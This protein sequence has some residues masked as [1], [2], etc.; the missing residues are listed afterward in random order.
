MATENK[1]SIYL[2]STL[3][4]GQVTRDPALLPQEHGDDSHCLKC[5]GYCRMAFLDPDDTR[6]L[7]SAGEIPYIG[8]GVED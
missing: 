1:V 8:D 7:P 4:E 5:G 3:S 6:L 2:D